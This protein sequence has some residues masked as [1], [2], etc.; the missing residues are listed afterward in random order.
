MP[1]VR[2]PQLQLVFAAAA[3]RL[4]YGFG[5]L[6][7]GRL[8]VGRIEVKIDPAQGARGFILTKNHSDLPIQ[9]DAVSKLGAAAFIRLNGFIQE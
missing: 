1:A 7:R 3:N 4:A 2:V 5:G 9:S 8:L 6:W